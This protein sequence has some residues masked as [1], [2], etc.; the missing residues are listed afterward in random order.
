MLI[1]FAFVLIS[2]MN[3]YRV[4][5]FE[6]QLEQLT[7]CLYIIKLKLRIAGFATSC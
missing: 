4:S 7:R 1:G 3:F 6:Q 2:T 5:F